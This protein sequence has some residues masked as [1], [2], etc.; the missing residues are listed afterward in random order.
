MFEYSSCY[1]AIES[2][3]SALAFEYVVFERWCQRF[4][5]VRMCI[6]ALI[7]K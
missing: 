6:R 3:T 2:D 1:I 4:R 5:N 7:F